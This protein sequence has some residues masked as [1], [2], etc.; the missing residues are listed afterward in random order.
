MPRG[1][2]CL[3]HVPYMPHP[4]YAAC[5][6]TLRIF[7]VVT[8]H[9][10]IE[11]RK[12]HQGHH[13]IQ[14]PSMLPISIRIYKNVWHWNNTPSDSK[15]DNNWPNWLNT[16][17]VKQMV[18]C[19]LWADFVLSLAP[20]CKLGSEWK[21]GRNKWRAKGLQGAL[22]SLAYTSMTWNRI[23]TDAIAFTALFPVEIELLAG[24]VIFRPLLR[25][26]WVVRH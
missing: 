1:V 2:V 23:L 7:S 4:R 14:G 17:N 8:C 16:W 9:R 21:S 24:R 18:G 11:K 6:C 15:L 19:C 20:R 10:L 5:V 13:V 26:C 25:K 22:S 3:G 12:I